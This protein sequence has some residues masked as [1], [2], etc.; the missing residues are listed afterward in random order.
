M[1][2]WCSRCTR[3]RSREDGR[4]CLYMQDTWLVTADGGV[5]LADLPMRIFDGTRRGRDDEPSSRSRCCPARAARTTSATCAPTSCSRCRRAPDEWVHRDE[6]LF[7]TVHQASELWLKLAPAEVAEATRLIGSATR[8]AI[9][10]LRRAD[11]LP[12]D[13]HR[14]ARHARAHVAVGVPGDAQ[15]ARPRQRL[16]L[17]RLPRRST[18]RAGARRRRSARRARPPGSRCIEVYTH[19]REHEELYQ[20]AELLIEWDERVVVWR[21]RHFVVVERVIGGASIGTQGTPVEVLGRLIHKRFFPEL[22]E[23]RNELTVRSRNRRCVSWPR[24]SLGCG[25]FGGIGS[26]PAFFGQGDDEEEACAIMDAAWAAASAGSTPPMPTAAAAARRYIGRWRAERRPDDLLITTK[27]VQLGHAATRT[28]T[29]SRRDRIRR[30]ARGQPRAARRRPDRPL[31]RPR[32][33]PGDAARGHGRDVRGAARR[34]G[35]RRLGAQQLRRRRDRGGARR[36]AGRRSSRTRTRSSTATTSGRA[37]AL[38]RAR[39]RL[40]PVRPARRR[41]AGREVPPR[42]AVPRRARG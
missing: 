17:A 22:W 18:G 14:R 34:R 12:E 19:G 33:G 38:R 36:T 1:Q 5:P 28:T 3:T 26:A 41:L 32:A 9:R 25:N 11:R 13:R 7:Q 42:R 39:H 2:A 27:V 10:L 8:G 16:R 21:V 24:L 29:G 15:G 23:V 6:L 31:P 30:A 40:R 37:A 20:L 4:A 35:D